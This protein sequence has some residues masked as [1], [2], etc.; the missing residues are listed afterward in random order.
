MTSILYGNTWVGDS[1]PATPV[2]A[3]QEWV[4]P[5]AGTISRRNSSNT[6]W[7]PTGSINAQTAVQKS[8]D[9]MTGP[10][11][12]VPNLA[13]IDSPDFQNT[14]Q[15]GG[16]NLATMLSLSQLRRGL[17]SY[18]DDSVRTQFLSQ[19]KLSG[20][21]ADIAASFQVLSFPIDTWVDADHVNGVVASFPVFQSDKVQAT[22]GQILAWGYAPVDS[23][24]QAGSSF[25]RITSTG[26]MKV[27][28]TWSGFTDNWNFGVGVWCLAVR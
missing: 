24:G 14:A 2:W 8:G 11:L 20:T 26:L 1:E 9:T 3:G 19:T 16:L 12:D 27:K 5:T 28:V 18:I 22:E 6:A 25:V 4:Q 7:V 23:L 15:L 13:P 10:L 21:A 17:L